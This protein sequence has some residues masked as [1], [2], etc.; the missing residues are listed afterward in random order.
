VT[1]G[2]N[3]LRETIAELQVSETSVNCRGGWGL[4][5]WRESAWTLFNELQNDGF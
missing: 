2:A 5:Q 3:G 4:R 1:V